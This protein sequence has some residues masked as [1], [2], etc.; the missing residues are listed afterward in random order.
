ME[1]K[2]RWKIILVILIIIVG[3]TYTAYLYKNELIDNLER[4]IVGRIEKNYEV[5]INFSEIK[6]WPFNQLIL[7]DLIIKKEGKVLFSGSELKIYYDLIEIIKEG[8]NFEFNN[9]EDSL[10][11]IEINKADIKLIDFSNSEKENNF[12][13]PPN[14]GRELAGLEISVFNSNL[15][16]E[17]N[18]YNFSLKNMDTELN[19]RENEIVIKNKSDLKINKVN[20]F[21]SKI[22][23]IDF[24]DLELQLVLTDNNDWE[25]KFNSNYFALAP[26]NETI[27]KTEILTNINENIN[28]KDIQ[29]NLKAN[30]EITGNEYKIKSYKTD[31]KFNNS[32]FLISESD[33]FKEGKINNINGDI[34]LS[35]AE[36]KIILDKFN[37]SLY[38]SDYS[39]TGNYSFENKTVNGKLNSYN[40][41]L[42]DLEKFF[43][44]TKKYSPQG[45]ARLSLDIKGSLKN[46]QAALD[47]YLNKGEIDNH[48]INNLRTE[49]R[50]RDGLLYLDQFDILIDN[51][52]NIMID[53]I[54]NHYLKEYNFTFNG[55]KIKTELINN[56][57]ENEQLAKLKGNLNLDFNISGKGFKRE[58]FNILGEI[59]MNS[60]EFGSL[61]SD[62]WF[63]RERLILDEGFLNIKGDYL[64]FSGEVNLEEEEFDLDLDGT[65][66]TLKNLGNKLKKIQSRKIPDIGGQMTFEAELKGNFSSPVL[67]GNFQIDNTKFNE[68]VF[69]DM[70]GELKYKEEV[71]AFDQFL[72]KDNDHKIKGKARVDFSQAAPY[73]E[74]DL[75]SDNLNYSY[76]KEKAVYFGMENLANIDLPFTGSLETDLELSGDFANPE[77]KGKISSTDSIFNVGN[78]EIAA[79]NILM[80]FN[81]DDEQLLELEKLELQKGE[82]LINLSG[83][84]SEAGYDLKYKGKNLNLTELGLST[85]LNI[86]LKAD[87]DLSGAV[88]GDLESPEIAGKINLK[89]II[90]AQNRLEN[91]EANYVYSNG[92]LKLNET[93]WKFAQSKFEINGKITD[94]L[95][96]A[97]LDLLVKTEKGNIDKILDLYSIDPGFNIGYFFEGEAEIKGDFTSPSAKL[98][99][100]AFSLDSN[101]SKININGVI[102]NQLKLN[103]IGSNVKLNKFIN[104]VDSELELKGSADFYGLLSGTINDYNLDLTTNVDQAIIEGFTANNIR[105]YLNYSKGSNLNIHQNFRLGDKGNISLDGKINPSTTE[106]DLEVI[107]ENLPLNLLENTV[108]IA[109]NIEGTADGQFAI[110]GSFS[111]PE[112]SGKLNFS[113]KEMDLSLPQKVNNYSGKLEFSNNYVEVTEFKAKYDQAN[114]SLAGR[115]YPFARESF[116]D[117]S[118]KGQNIPLDHGSFRGQFDTEEIKV[119]GSL[120]EPKIAGELLTHDLVVSTPFNWPTT[121]GESS[122][123]PQLELTLKPGKEVYFRSGRNID[124]PVQE[125]ELTL[126]LE[127]EFQMEGQLTSRQGTFDYYNNKFIVNTATA[128]FRRFEG[129]VPTVHVD[130]NTMVDG[131]RVNL[132]LDGPA[133]NMIVSFT[134]QPDLEQNEIMA[135]LTQKGGIA[136]F[137]NKDELEEDDISE[138]VRREFMRILQG[139]FQLSFISDLE[140]DLEDMLRLDRIEIDTYELGWN[141]E[142]TIRAGKNITDKL[143][144]EYTNTVG[145]DSIDNEISISYPL[146]EK[147]RFEGSWYGNSEFSLRI[148]TVIEF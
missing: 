120:F 24:A 30:L 15:K 10:N 143:Y 107:S 21:E 74:A 55:R 141:D 56:Y 79:D 123:Q 26:F 13:I 93:F 114:F 118:L 98:D 81:L 18:N 33:Y 111:D 95:N 16:S 94:I 125:G 66:L 72:L 77:I 130:A 6:I 42:K 23:D 29:G 136:E 102:N 124:V 44:K 35:S 148:D 2:F 51:K 106:M 83:L 104:V 131:V 25:L 8:R 57:L 64:N 128:T 45:K 71:L 5:E 11:Y 110:N 39:F 63:G 40:F 41:A 105:G 115:V 60:P 54:Y 88:K 47:I 103:L 27:N 22:E 62:L 3:L 96:E 4:D 146:T 46:P 145:V 70:E 50:Y 100:S 116:W 68:L 82:T 142:I 121:E 91:L 134:S 84:I 37:F 31:L 92:D 132:R 1:K 28:I 89:N 67:T 14:L 87:A 49:A 20:I 147:T 99:L 80:S 58:D 86:D 12:I 139:T 119:S 126:F 32:S 122:F 112:L 9:L 90:Y 19:F 73:F 43:S 117:L 65:E 101:D 76:I 78:K 113:G 7:E 53:G 69:G 97:K 133:D 135:L 85:L 38:E 61:Y 34:L 127:D 140:T 48:K 108:E 75:S 129:V 59:E 138:L 144:L 52:S 137:I 17:I 109:S 36:N